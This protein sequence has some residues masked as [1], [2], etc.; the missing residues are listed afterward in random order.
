[1]ESLA[2]S[3]AHHYTREHFST[4][5]PTAGSLA[6]RLRLSLCDINLSSCTSDGGTDAKPIIPA[7]HASV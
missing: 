5:A 7:S 1:M 2:G 4:I 6:T 3:S